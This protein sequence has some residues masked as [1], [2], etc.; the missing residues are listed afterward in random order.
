MTL[1][2]SLAPPGDGKRLSGEEGNAS[3]TLARTA[4]WRRPAQSGLCAK[5]RVR[6]CMLGVAGTLLAASWSMTTAV[7]VASIG[8]RRQDGTR[9]APEA[10]PYCIETERLVLRCWQPADARDLADAAIGQQEWFAFAPW[11]AEVQTVED[12]LAFARA[13]RGCFDLMRDFAFALWSKAPTRLL[14]GV[15]L[16]C[17]DP[18]A[19]R[20]TLDYWLRKDAT[21][22]GYAR[23]GVAAILDVAIRLVR[24]SRVEI[25]VAV[26]N[27]KSR[28]L[29]A[30]LG[31]RKDGVM[32]ESLMV[33]GRLLDMVVYSQLAKDYVARQAPPERER[34][35]VTSV[36]TLSRTG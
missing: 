26:N 34:I 32:R 33:G 8:S 36:G 35:C 4:S 12:A 10:I 14:G 22:R 29:P 25:L 27:A 1:F 7:R 13:S 24:A 30:A 16:H 21:G 5:P 23:E 11:V 31:F 17:A 20:V 2:V 15:Q 19:C 6:R 18:H 3:T 9:L 28:A